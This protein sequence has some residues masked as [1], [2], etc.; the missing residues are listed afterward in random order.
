MTDS[1]IWLIVPPACCHPFSSLSGDDAGN[2]IDL[3]YASRPET[4][5]DLSS[6]STALTTAGVVDN[7]ESHST[8]DLC[9]QEIHD[10]DCKI[11]SRTRNAP[12]PVQGQ[13]DRQ[14]SEST[15][16]RM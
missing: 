13:L 7:P 15:H 12:R 16:R 6:D 5:S 14:M 11:I 8:D 4:P 2:I 1:G 3:Y 10:S 9:V